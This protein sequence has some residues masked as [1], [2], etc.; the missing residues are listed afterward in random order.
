MTRPGFYKLDTAANVLRHAPTR[1]YAP[2]YTLLAA[3]KDTYNYPVDGW[4][5][6]DTTEEAE[7]ALGLNGQTG[8]WVAF[9][10]AVMADPGINA[11]LGAALQAAPALFQG[12]GV[13]LGKAADGDSR[14]FIGAWTTA[15]ALGLISAQLIADIQAMATQYQLPAEFIAALDPGK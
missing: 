6:F 7:I 11:M 14:V 4:T 10:N 1:V 13:G 8:E 2:N 9:G 3:E 15:H 12:L 5:W